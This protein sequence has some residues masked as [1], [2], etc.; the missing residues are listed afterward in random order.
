MKVADDSLQMMLLVAKDSFA[1]AS[2][3]V[4]NI[5]RYLLWL[6]FNFIFQVSMSFSMLS[7]AFKFAAQETH[8]WL[9]LRT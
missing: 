3:Y 2:T 1:A 8:A 4:A 6:F 9:H 5:L 7:S